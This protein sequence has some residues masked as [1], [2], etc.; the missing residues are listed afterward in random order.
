MSDLTELVALTVPEGRRSEATRA[1]VG[2]CKT[3]RRT[4][5]D[6]IRS[7]QVTLTL[8]DLPVSNGSVE[9]YIQRIGMEQGVMARACTEGK[10]VT[11]YLTRTS[12]PATSGNDRLPSEVAGWVSRFFSWWSR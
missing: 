8:D 12:F 4:S 2:A 6:T 3:L 11:V 1:L 5:P 10:H 9:D 7:L